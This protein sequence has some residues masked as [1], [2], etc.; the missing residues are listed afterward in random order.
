MTV[1]PSYCLGLVGESR[2]SLARTVEMAWQV[3]ERGQPW[4]VACSILIPFIGTR[5]YRQLVRDCPEAAASRRDAWV[6]PEDLQHWWAQTYTEV[7]WPELVAAMHEILRSAPLKSTFG[8]PVLEERSP[9]C[10]P[11]TWDQ[12]RVA[13]R[14]SAEAR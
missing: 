10:D 13:N 6:P 12:I 14:R 3:A 7:E 1:F 5:A 11:A 4:E 8:V 9:Y 2:E